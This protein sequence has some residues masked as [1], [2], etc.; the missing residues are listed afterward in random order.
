MHLSLAKLQKYIAFAN[1][2]RYAFQ[3]LEIIYSIHSK[4]WY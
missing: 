3:F 2:D 1:V 4:H